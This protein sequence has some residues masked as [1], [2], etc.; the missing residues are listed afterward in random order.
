MNQPDSLPQRMFLLA[1]NPAK[2]KTTTGLYLRPLIRS[3]ALTELYLTGYLRDDNGKP[4]VEVEG[5]CAD[6]V[7]ADVLEEIASGRPRRWQHWVGRSNR[8]THLAVRQQLLDGGVLKAERRRIL[9]IFPT[10]RYLLRDPRVRTR[11][12]STVAAVLRDPVSRADP[13][14]A[15][16]VALAVQGRLNH[17][18]PRA[19]RREHKRKIAALTEVAGPAAPALKKTIDSY[20]AA[21]AG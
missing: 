11:L 14:D 4:A 8:H 20:A 9:G 19:K 13:V 21:A 7:L 10:T 3:A 1:L 2:G 15:A 12:V 6:T 17:V 16:L 18:V 5:P